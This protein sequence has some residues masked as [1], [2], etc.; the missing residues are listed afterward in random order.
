MA[1]PLDSTWPPA[2][3]LPVGTFAA[4]CVAHGLRTRRPRSELRS[5][6]RTVHSLLHE[7]QPCTVQLWRRR[8][9]AGM[10]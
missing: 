3:N 2:L 7:H 5:K 10:Y 4:L 6:V 9:R 8:M 1:Q